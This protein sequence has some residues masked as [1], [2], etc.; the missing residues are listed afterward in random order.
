VA[1][2][3]AER[4]HVREM[5]KRDLAVVGELAGG[6]VRQHH[7]W[8][9]KR[10]MLTEGVEEGYRWWLGK[11][12]GEKSAVL[13]VAELD[14]QVVGYLYGTLEERDWALLL[15]DHGVVHDVYVDAKFRRR[16]VARALMTEGVKRL[17]EKGAKRITLHSAT[18][19]VHAQKLFASLGFRNTM[20]E[21]TRGG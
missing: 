7:A 15:D 8:D 4:I 20:V 16:G 10:F 3:R 5:T 18:P 9:A 6:L 21:M 19:N 17:E 14:G 12:L 1:A 13:L 2:K 11:N